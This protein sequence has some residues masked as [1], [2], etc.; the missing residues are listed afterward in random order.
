M[1][2]VISTLASLLLLSSS[3]LAISDCSDNARIVVPNIGP[4]TLANY[5]QK[6]EDAREDLK[7]KPGDAD[8]LIWVGRRT[9]YLGNYKE[10]ISLFSEGVEK[11]PS[12][13]RFLRHRGHRYISIRCFD[14]AIA[15]LRK[16]ES[17]VKGKPDEVEPDGLPNAR[18][19]PTSTLQSNIF[20]HLGLAYYLKG[21][22][23]NALK[24][25]RKCLKVSRNPDMFVATQNWH[26]LTLMRLGKVDDSAKLLRTVKEG[27]DVIENDSY[28]KL[29]KLYQNKVHVATLLSEIRD[30][31]DALQNATMGYGIGTYFLVWGDREKAETVYRKILET[32]QWSSFGY[33][34]AEAELARVE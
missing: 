27:L 23:K 21:D 19:I 6:L 18:N 2:T 4:E 20:Y 14:D 12:D 34:A 26:Y 32:D 9:A 3:I 13:P 22:F 31:S 7:R 11:F 28:Y 16:A 24:T 1:K 5:T 8:A 10:A 17:L 33:I 25:Y 15:D 30:G 29:L